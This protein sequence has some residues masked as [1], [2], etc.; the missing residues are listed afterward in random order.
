MRLDNMEQFS[1]D[2]GGHDVKPSD[3]FI[4]N[5]SIFTKLFTS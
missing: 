3:T 1:H 4:L 5:I 2:F